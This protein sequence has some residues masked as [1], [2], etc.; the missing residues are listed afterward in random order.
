M[1]I[2]LAIYAVILIA[3]GEFDFITPILT[4][5][6]VVSWQGHIN[7]DFMMFL[8]LAGL[9]IAWRSGF[10]AS[11]I[12]LGLFTVCSGMLFFSVYLAYQLSRCDNDPRQLL[13]GVHSKA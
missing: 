9:W 4:A 1:F 13:L 12:A 3:N 5:L 6:F 10:T 11:G 8:T 7:L 2:V